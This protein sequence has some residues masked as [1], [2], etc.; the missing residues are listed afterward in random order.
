MYWFFTNFVIDRT[1]IILIRQQVSIFKTIHPYSRVCFLIFS[2]FPS[3]SVKF[4]VFP[5]IYLGFMKNVKKK[6]LGAAVNEIYV[7]IRFRSLKNNMGH[8]KKITKP[9]FQ[10]VSTHMLYIYRFSSRGFLN[11]FCFI[12]KNFEKDLFPKNYICKPCYEHRK[13]NHF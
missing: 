9:F 1:F 7:N 13:K 11:Y 2:L 3:F 4:S 8:E 12:K 10:S 5:F 6:K